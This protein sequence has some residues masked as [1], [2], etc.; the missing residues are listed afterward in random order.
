MQ[1][2]SAYTEG[3]P[4]EDT[5][6]LPISTDN[7]ETTLDLQSSPNEKTFSHSKYDKRHKWNTKNSSDKQNKKKDIMKKVRKDLQ[8]EKKA[9]MGPQAGVEPETVSDDDSDSGGPSQSQKQEEYRDRLPYSRMAFNIATN[10]CA[11]EC[12]RQALLQQE[13]QE[14][15]HKEAEKPVELLDTY[16]VV[17]QTFAQMGVGSDDKILNIVENIFILYIKLSRDKTWFDVSTTLFQYAKSH[18]QRSATKIVYD[19]MIS[20]FADE[21]GLQPQAGSPAPTWLRI[22][23]DSQ[24]NWNLIRNNPGFVKVSKLIAVCVGLGLCDLT[25]LGFG[26]ES[27]SKFVESAKKAHYTAPDLLSAVMSTF[28]HFME[29][30]YLCFTTG[31]M[32]PFMYGDMDTQRFNELYQTCMLNIEYHKCGNLYSFSGLSDADFAKQLDDCHDLAEKLSRLSAGSF[33][34]AALLRYRDKI[35]SWKA[36]FNQT[37]MSGGLRV[38]PYTIGVFGGTAVGKSTLANILMVYVL[39]ANGFDASDERLVTINESDKYDSNMRSSVTGVFIDDLGNTKAQFVNEAP[40]TKLIRYCNNVKN[41]AVMAGVEQKGK[42]AIEPKVVMITKNVK[43][44][45]ATVYSNE[46]TSITRREHITLTVT[47]RDEFAENGRLDPKKVRA[48]GLGTDP[49]PDLWEICVQRSTLVMPTV[50]GKPPSIGWETIDNMDGIS[51]Y[52]L[53]EWL[54]SET[55]DY[56]QCQ[57]ELVEVS[58]NLSN[59]IDLCGECSLPM[60]ICKCKSKSGQ[61]MDTQAGNTIGSALDVITVANTCIKR[62][63]GIRDG[64]SPSVRAIRFIVGCADKVFSTDMRE[65]LQH[66]ETNLLLRVCSTLPTYFMDVDAVAKYCVVR[67][68]MESPAIMWVVKYMTIVMM[69]WSMYMSCVST[70]FQVSITIP[71]ILLCMHFALEKKKLYKAM[72]ED[73]RSVDQIIGRFTTN[74]TLVVA[75]YCIGLLAVYKMVKLAMASRVLMD[76]GKQMFRKMSNEFIPQGSLDPAD[77]EEI[78]ARDLEQNVWAVPRVAKTP[79]S[80]KM[81]TTTSAQLVAKVFKNLVHLTITTKEGK[82]FGTDGFFLRSNM[83][84]LPKHAMIDDEMRAD[85]TRNES[86]GGRFRTNLSRTYM[87]EIP[88][89]DLVVVWVPNGGEWSDITEYLPLAEPMDCCAQLVHKKLDGTQMDS[90]IFCKAGKYDSAGQKQFV[91]ATYHTRFKT[92]RGLCMSAVVSDTKNPCIYGF[93]VAGKNDTTLGCCACVMKSAVL[94]AIQDIGCI[95]G[96]LSAAS[97]GTMPKSSFDVQFFEGEKIHPKSPLNFLPEAEL[98]TYT[99]YGSVIGRAKYYSEVVPTPISDCVAKVCSYPQNWGKPKFGKDYPW[100]KALYKRV[101]P[102]TGVPGNYLKWAV[103]DYA[104]HLL[105]NIRSRRGLER[106]IVPLTR[107]QTINGIC[108]KRF[109]DKMPGST[110]IGFPLTGPKDQYYVDVLVPEDKERQDCVDLGGRRIIKK[111]RLERVYLSGERAYPVLKA[112]LKDEPTPLDKDKVRDF[113]AL[114]VAVQLIVRKYFL[115][116]ARVMSMLPIHSECAVGINAHGPEWQQ[117]HEY[118]TM[119]GGSR[120]LAGDYKAYDLKMPAQ[121]TQAAFAILIDMA[122]EF[123]YDDN[124]LMIMRGVATDLTYP[125]VAYN[126][127]LISF[128]NSNPSGHNL[129]V[130]INCIVNSLLLRCAFCAE[131]GVMDNIKFKEVCT[132]ITYGDDFIGSV[133]PLYPRYNHVTAARFMASIGMELTMPDKKSSPIPYLAIEN[134][135]FLKR[136]SVYHEALGCHVGALDEA[137]IFKSLHSVL[138]STALTTKEQSICNI[139]GA[140]REWFAHGPELYE[141]RRLQMVEVATQCEI[142]H[143][144][145]EIHFSYEDRVNMW[146]VK[147][148]AED[149]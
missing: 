55:R 71:I 88:D 93:H 102:A 31:S 87:V 119:Y 52:R 136:K 125:L 61:G 35:V 123:G 40:T 143:A 114:P 79:V 6:V 2:L 128:Y 84:M 53:I 10:V 132:L 22:L 3:V 24:M 80:E 108:G 41:Y 105:K 75:K 16:E 101:T 130:Y 32:K 72:V 146:R 77:M 38:A 137:S 11:N 42:V 25:N 62:V 73:R 133:N 63:E 86:P 118:I 92:F 127:D 112:C 60:R 45:C 19:C 100:Q 98:T 69:L 23:R 149:G 139:D 47:V 5:T 131:Y 74:H 28:V 148:L 57:H 13:Q 83:M 120:T 141:Y 142:A 70:S 65:R 103:E 111:K 58:G 147:Y 126:G 56:F 90:L 14:A 129:T 9:A 117:M 29:C 27:M 48:A 18:T 107:E 104:N 59:K 106:E 110:A 67:M 96:V 89:H 138:R 135:D 122:K 134:T 34:R 46:P 97:E 76:Y 7:A 4:C 85:V 115:P 39:K 26:K 94:Q 68:Y 17:R 1:P 82:M 95:P 49:I 124:A 51:I 116:I 36:E 33:E 43:D 64:F 81:R 15:M 109:V 99:A 21:G 66:M 140:V 44:S 54:R 144:C 37:R 78:N 12:A 145:K 30:G 91:G 113:L 20:V 50:P 121:L 8:T